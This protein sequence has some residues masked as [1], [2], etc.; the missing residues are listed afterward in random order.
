MRVPWDII[1][2]DLETAGSP[3][4]RIC[5]IGA[6]RLDRDLR[7]VNQYASLVD[8][9]CPLSDEVIAVHGI[10]QKDLVGFPNFAKVHE[11]FE[12]WCDASDSYLFAAFG[13][14]FDIPVLRAEYARIGMEFPH[15]GEALDIK[16]V[17]WWELLRR[18]LPPAKLKLDRALEL[19]GLTFEGQ[20]HR[21]LPDA[22]NEARLLQALA[23]RP[24]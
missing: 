16:A 2:F 11:Q 22:V 3:G 8:P 6:V 5:E 17:A 12:D 19:M 15:R 20:R 9:E 1:V 21:A 4:H 7:I 23:K 13:A 18:G 10:T 24:T 14:Y